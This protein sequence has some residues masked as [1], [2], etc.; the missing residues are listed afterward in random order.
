MINKIVVVGGTSAGFMTALALKAKIPELNVRLIRVP[1]LEP[2]VNESSTIALTRFLHGYLQIDLTRFIRGSKSNWTLGHLLHWGPRDHFILPYTTQLDQRL[3]SLPRNNAFYAEHDLDCAGALYALLAYDRPFFRLE[4]GQPAWHWDVGY[5]IETSLFT[6][7]LG[8]LAT[9]IGV[10]IHDDTLTNVTQSGNGVSGL[11][12]GSGQTETA[13]LYVDCSG[14][15]SLLLGQALKEPFVSFK[16]TLACDRMVVGEWGRTDEAIH[17]HTFCET[18]EAGWAWQTEL[19]HRIDC[20]YVFSSNSISD[21]QATRE[22]QSKCPKA[23]SPR[24]LRTTRGRYERAWVKNVVA[25]GAAAGYVEPLAST[26]LSIAATEARL[27]VETISEGGRQVSA[28]PVTLY[29]RQHARVWDS[30]RRFLAIHYKFNTRLETPFW[31]ACRNDTDLAGADTIIEYYRQCGPSSLW[32]P[33]LIDPVDLFGPASYLGLLLG[34]KVSTRFHLSIP[35]QERETWDKECQ[36]FRSAATNGV[37]V[38][39]ALSMLPA[40]GSAAGRIPL[41]RSATG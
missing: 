15:R 14:A 26:A 33:M 35:A 41:G 20:G 40:T 19:V 13:D 17:P 25:I 9:A 36:R 8:Q 5:Q 1:D 2:V 22:L 39:E 31:K 12:L 32:G 29:N 24:V 34:M 30:V 11:V 7:T 28:A 16:S 10:E 27:L 4:N 38:A 37:T 6:H 18:M 21:D 3:P 23:L